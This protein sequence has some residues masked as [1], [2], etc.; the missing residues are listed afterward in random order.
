MKKTNLL[1]PMML[2]VL[3]SFNFMSDSN[4]ILSY[5]K[6]DGN[7]V[8]TYFQNN[9]IFN[10]NFENGNAGLLSGL[11]IPGCFSDTVRI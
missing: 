11:R 6:I 2:L 8:S 7:N 9:G 5:K 3:L 4:L 10:R 1:I